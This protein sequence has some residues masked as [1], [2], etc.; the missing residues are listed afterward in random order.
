M[1][2]RLYLC[3]TLL[4]SF[5]SSSVV[6]DEIRVAVASNFLETAKAL[7]EN[8]EEESEH[9]LIFSAG[10]SGKHFAQIVNGAPFD[11]FLA[12]DVERPKQLEASGRGVE[13]SRFTYAVGEIV[14][15][16]PDEDLVDPEGAIL[17]GDDFQYL[18]LANPRLAPYGKAAQQILENKKLWEPLSSKI[19]QGENI[20]QTFQFISSRNAQLGFVSLSQI[21]QPGQSIQGSYASFDPKSYDPIEQQ[22][23][24]LTD[25]TGA[26]EF[27]EFLQSKEAQAVIQSYGYSTTM[28]VQSYEPSA[29]VHNGLK[30]SNW[31]AVWLTFRLALISTVILLILG[32][33]LAWWLATTRFRYKSAIEAAVA[34][35]IILPPTV[36]GFYLLIAL[37]PSGPIGR[38]LDVIG[39]SPIVF[40]FTGL[41]VGSIIYSLPFVV[42]PLQAAMSAIGQGPREVAATLRASPWDRFFSVIIPLAWPGFLTASVL[43]FAHTVGEFGVVL[44]IGGNIPDETKVLSISI[45]DH[46]EALDYG[47]AHWLAGGL[48]AF[49]FILLLIVYSLNRKIM[50]FNR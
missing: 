29:K 38:L 49:S 17:R 3:F 2:L 26:R 16:S 35:P 42:Q 6:G 24:Q 5:V 50:T 27:L 34:L 37:G 36:L 19:V 46:V 10:S 8:F 43:G 33:P 22:A 44:M 18:A 1:L 9:E 12:A 20:S 30:S 41:V 39:V 45:Y 31:S 40:T 23:V 14:L 47:Q 48:L 7:K 21:L 11:V 28:D 4:A 15:W 25:K 13:G 32:T